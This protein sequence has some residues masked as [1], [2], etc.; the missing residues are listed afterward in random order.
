MNKWIVRSIEW[1]PGCFGWSAGEDKSFFRLS[2][3]FLFLVFE[4]EKSWDSACSFRS[5]IRQRQ[6]ATS[7][8]YGGL[9]GKYTKM[10]NGVNENIMRLLLVIEAWMGN[11]QT[12]IPE[13]MEIFFMN[14][15]NIQMQNATLY[16]PYYNIF[17]D[18]TIIHFF[19]WNSILIR[20]NWQTSAKYQTRYLVSRPT[21]QKIRVAFTK[22]LVFVMVFHFQYQSW[23]SS[24]K[25]KKKGEKKLWFC[26]ILIDSNSPYAPPRW[27]AMLP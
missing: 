13:I 22:K 25:K 1:L 7:L 6:S 3:L 18:Q 19:F 27:P 15:V 10:G 23:N 20:K 11:T 21:R 24:I 16:H 8:G 4:R 12:W 9:N 17:R 26:S 5:Q 14:Q 2:F